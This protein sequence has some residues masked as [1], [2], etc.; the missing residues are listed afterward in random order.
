MKCSG[1]AERT[2]DVL[3]LHTVWLHDLWALPSRGWFYFPAFNSPSA[4]GARAPL[5]WRERET[6]FFWPLNTSNRSGCPA[7]FHSDGAW[8]ESVCLLAVNRHTG[9]CCCKV[10]IIGANDVMFT[11]WPHTLTQTH[12]S[13]GY[14]KKCSVC[15]LWFSGSHVSLRRNNV[16]WRRKLL[17]KRGFLQRNPLRCVWLLGVC[18]LSHAF[19]RV[20]LLALQR[21]VGSIF[22]FFNSNV[23]RSTYRVTS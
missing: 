1:R 13:M 23:I 16:L 10:M 5:R 4:P 3:N 21:G 14:S 19:I 18:S 17:H 11:S 20:L 8:M 22:F 2:P 15:A 9:C 12:I 7:L 6:R